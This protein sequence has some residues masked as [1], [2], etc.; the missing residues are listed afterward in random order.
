M[1]SSKA[2][3]GKERRHHMGMD[4]WLI[5]PVSN[6]DN[7]TQ[8]QPLSLAVTDERSNCRSTRTGASRKYCPPV[9]HSPPD[10][11]L[12]RA[13]RPSHVLPSTAGSSEEAQGYRW[14]NRRG[15]GGERRRLGLPLKTQAPQVNFNLC[16]TNQIA[17]TRRPQRS[18]PSSCNRTH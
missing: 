9:R 1:T 16:A 8:E 18:P 10:L 13:S 12:L 7:T 14:G 5:R 4:Y 6:L 2:R 17:S 15:E 11:P 3:V